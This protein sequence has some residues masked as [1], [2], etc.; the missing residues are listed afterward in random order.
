MVIKFPITS[1][2][3]I[4][5]HLKDV[6][7]RISSG[8]HIVGRMR[9]RKMRRRSYILYDNG[10]KINSSIEHRTVASKKLTNVFFFERPEVIERLMVHMRI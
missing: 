4:N 3:I 2:P 8:A 5:S 9:N 10:I 6:G 1:K 7:V